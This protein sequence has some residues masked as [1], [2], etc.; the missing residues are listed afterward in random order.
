[1]III[2]VD[3]VI[4]CG[5]S[6]FQ[7][8][9]CQI[10]NQSEVWLLTLL[11]QSRAENLQT[12]IISFIGLLFLIYFVL[13]SIGLY[14]NLDDMEFDSQHGQE[15]FLFSKSPDWLWDPSSLILNE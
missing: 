11:V 2:E 5:K 9:A 6:C 13:V 12:C 14:C 7:I 10:R 3:F 1:M 4:T 8:L 15:I